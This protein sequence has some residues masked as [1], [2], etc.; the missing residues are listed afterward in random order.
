M[1]V[2]GPGLTLGEALAF[3]L[4]LLTMPIIGAFFYLEEGNM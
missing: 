1:F 3:G 4:G 2:S